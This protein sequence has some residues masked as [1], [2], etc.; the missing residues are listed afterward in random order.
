MTTANN[1]NVSLIAAKGLEA[2]LLFSSQG[3]ATLTNST[4]ESKRGNIFLCFGV[5]VH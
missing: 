4:L 1:Y 3:S 5:L 2:S